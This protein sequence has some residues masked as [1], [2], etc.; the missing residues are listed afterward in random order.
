LRITNLNKVANTKH[1]LV[2]AAMH[3]WYTMHGM[4]TVY[5]HGTLPPPKRFVIKILTNTVRLLLTKPPKK[6]F[7]DK[8]L[9]ELSNEK[10]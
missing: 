9:V 4:P 10:S 6:L 5:G 7:L 8:N 1:W 2:G 3:T